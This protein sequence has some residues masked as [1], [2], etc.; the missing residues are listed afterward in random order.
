MWTPQ[1]GK[2]ATV[3]SAIFS[4]LLSVGS[5]L[6]RL[7]CVGFDRTDVE[8]IAVL[9]GRLPDLSYLFRTM[10]MSRDHISYCLDCFEDGGALLVVRTRDVIHRQVVL[11]IVRQHGGIVPPTIN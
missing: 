8:V 3:V 10:G 9:S 4:D 11:G 6:K 2:S 7:G 1:N 5:A